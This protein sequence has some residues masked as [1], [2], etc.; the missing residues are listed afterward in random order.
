MSVDLVIKNGW[1]VLPGE[2]FA[3]G[4]AIDA[5]KFVAI[6]T[7]SG[8]RDVDRSDSRSQSLLLFNRNWG[9]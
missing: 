4:L 8:C 3:G 6:G 2:T 1:V 7:E 9:L 5:E